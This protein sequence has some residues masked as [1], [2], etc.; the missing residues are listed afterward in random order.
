MGIMRGF[1]MS[2]G[3]EGMFTAGYLGIGPVIVGELQNTYQQSEST[4]KMCGAIASGIIAASVSHPLDTIKTCMQGDIAKTSYGSVSHTASELYA[5]G[6]PSRF[7]R[8][9][10][11]RTGRMICAMFIMNECKLRLSPIFFPHHFV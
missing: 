2:C 6:G 9:Y 7:F 5:E 4:A 1:W 10:A 8:G 3:R 11:W